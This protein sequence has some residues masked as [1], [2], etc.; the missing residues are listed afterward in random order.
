M[1]AINLQI[2]PHTRHTLSSHPHLT[3][4]YC[5][6][7]IRFATHGRWIQL[8]ISTS[9]TTLLS[10]TGRLRDEKYKFWHCVMSIGRR[11]RACKRLSEAAKAL[12]TRDHVRGISGP[13]TLFNTPAADDDIVLAGGSET[14]IEAWGE[15]T[16]PLST[17]NGIKTTTLKRV[18]L[19]PSFFTSLVSLS[20]LTSSDIHFDSGQNVLYR[21]G[22]PRE[23]IGK[24]TR[25]GGHWLVVHRSQPAAQPPLQH[26]A[27][28]TN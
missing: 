4:D 14:P 8:L 2:D 1:L 19:I 15:V 20:R 12:T 27:F 3:T 23:D 16:I 22:T 18:A 6:T 24:L 10:S 7:T 5:S 13:S 11:V 9:A 25:L 17:L 28:A 26:A 21:A